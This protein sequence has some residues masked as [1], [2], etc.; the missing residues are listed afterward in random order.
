MSNDN[1]PPMFGPSTVFDTATYE[2]RSGKSFWMAGTDVSSLANKRV[3]T[4]VLIGNC[5]TSI[6]FKFLSTEERLRGLQVLFAEA[7]ACKVSSN[8]ARVADISN[9]IAQDVFGWIVLPDDARRLWRTADGELVTLTVDGGKVWNVCMHPWRDGL[10]D[11]EHDISFSP[12]H[13]YHTRLYVDW[14]A[15]CRDRVGAHAKQPVIAQGI[16]A[17]GLVRAGDVHQ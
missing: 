17:D 5:T 8:H 2:P 1:K 11:P 7:D 12:G 4:E 10:N 16:E 3:E 14:R 13:N 15:W 9:Q 6:P